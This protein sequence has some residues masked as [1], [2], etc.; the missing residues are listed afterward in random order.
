M[1]IKITLIVLLSFFLCS[2]QND[3]IFLNNKKIVCS[4]NEITTDAVKFTYPNETLT[5]SIY[6]NTIQ[7]ISFSSGRIQKFN[8]STSY[9]SVD[10]VSDFDNVSITRV[11]GEIK[12]LFKLGEVSSKAVGTT[13]FSNQEQVKERAY[14]KLKIQA[15]FQNG[16]IIYLTDQRTEGAKSGFYTSSKA[17]TNLTGILYTTKLPNFNQFQKLIGNKKNFTAVIENKLRNSSFGMDVKKIS[18]DFEIQSIKN[19]NSLIIITGKLK[20]VKKQSTFRVVSFTDT[21]FNI[22]YDGKR[23][24]Y[25]VKIN[26]N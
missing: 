4:V 23:A 15:S 16:N 21:S 8:E 19:E 18:K 24:E 11:E 5:N 2:A 9:K 22:F 10:N 1:K 3:T 14:K 17:E 13:V 7:S 6:K 25:N 20:G 12:G 26:L